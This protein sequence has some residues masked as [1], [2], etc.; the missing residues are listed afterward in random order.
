MR[1][2]GLT[3]AVSAGRMRC[4]RTWPR[5]TSMTGSHPRFAEPCPALP[6]SCRRRVRSCVRA[7]LSLS[8][9]LSLSPFLARSLARLLALSAMSSADVR[10]AARDVP[11]KPPVNMRPMPGAARPA[12]KGSNAP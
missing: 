9:S 7:C 5:C 1:C 6:P 8:L 11:A 12:A 2:P 10:C 4:F 3:P